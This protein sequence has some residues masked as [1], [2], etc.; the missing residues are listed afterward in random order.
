MWNL[1]RDVLGSLRLSESTLV[2]A[3]APLRLHSP[4]DRLSLGSPWLFRPTLVSDSA[5]FG[6]IRLRPGRASMEP[7]LRVRQTAMAPLLEYERQ[8]V[9]ELLDT[10]GL[11]VCARGL[12][13]D[14]LL[15]HFLRLHCHPACLVLVLNTQ[16]AEEVRPRWRGSE[17]TPRMLGGILSGC[18]VSD[19]DRGALRGIQAP[20][21]TR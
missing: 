13:A 10:D 18:E 21:T 19:R 9:L 8:L 14:R 7:V 5:P 17:G 6:F 15:Y 3:S 2:L 12:G 4:H 16:S 1:K 20:D 11:V